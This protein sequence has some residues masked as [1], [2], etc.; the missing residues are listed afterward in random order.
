M[1]QQ[2]YQVREHITIYSLRTFEMN[3]ALVFKDGIK[4]VIWS[5]LTLKAGSKAA[6]RKGQNKDPSF[7]YFWVNLKVSLSSSFIMQK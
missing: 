3:M 2:V 4:N 7:S 5:V 6:S 1:Y